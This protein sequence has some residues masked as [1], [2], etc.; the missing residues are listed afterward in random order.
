MKPTTIENLYESVRQR[1]E[2]YPE[3][4]A[5]G[6][7]Q[8]IGWRAVTSRELLALVDQLASEIAVNLGVVSGDRVVLWIPGSWQAPVYH[9]ALWKLGAVIVPLDKDTNRELAVAIMRSVE[10]RV[11]LVGYDYRPEWLTES[12]PV[13]EWWEPG[14]RGGEATE[15][16]VTN[17]LALIAFTSG[18]TGNP[19]GCMISHANLL[20][21]VDALADNVP[22]GPGCRL[23]SVLP[24]S[25]LL[26][27]T[28][29]MLYPLAAG[30]AVHYVPSRRGPDILSVFQQQRITHLIAVPQL[31]GLMGDAIDAQLRKTLPS[32]VYRTLLTVATRVPFAARRRLF[33][34][35][36]QK[37]GGELSMIACG[38]A[39]LPREVQEAWERFGIRVLQGYGASECAP[40]IAC[41]VADGS[42]PVGSVGKPIRGATMRLTLEGEVLVR[43]PN[44]MRGY[45]RDPTRTAEVLQDGWYSTGDLGRI[46]EGGN[47]WILGRA[48]DL[49]VLPSGL[50][51]WPEDLEAVLR[52]HPA[53]KD[54]AVMAVSKP[55]GGLL[56]HTHLIPT[57]DP[58]DAREI[59]AWVNQRLAAHQR[60]ATASWWE[61]A[62]GDFPRTATMKVR[63]HLLPLPTETGPAVPPSLIGDPVGRAVARVLK[64][65]ATRG[66]QTL[67]QLGV[68]SL[69]TLE[70]Q[71]QI[72]DESGKTLPDGFLQGDLTLDDLRRAVEALP[73]D[74]TGDA[75][76]HDLEAAGGNTSR[77]PFTWGRA[78][79]TFAL[80]LDVLFHRAATRIVVSGAENLEDLPRAVI[81]AG[82]HRSYPDLPLLRYAL[83]KTGR[84]ELKD[85]LIIAAAS[86]LYANAG[87][88]G[89][90]GTLLFGIY[91]IQQY[92]R[93][94]ESLS[95]L[96]RL[97]NDGSAILIFP[98]GHHTDP[99]LERAGDPRANF[100]PGV[101]HL[102]D[103]LGASVVPFGAAGSDLIV[104]PHPAADFRGIII[105]GGIPLVIHRAPVAICFGPPL[106]R[107]T[108]E[109][110]A[111]FAT[112]LQQTCFALAR[113]AEAAIGA[114]QESRI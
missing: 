66:D 55:R 75:L 56:L 10:P 74:S 19:K 18:S 27:L 6:G 94:R 36:H 84:A 64:L 93:Q 25:H 79:R 60:L 51:V 3:S 103:A 16:V 22:L 110:P 53:V 106:R 63:R 61:S 21:E 41:A 49:I 89:L 69:T 58:G 78:F 50:N 30:A 44:V 111:A 28:C 65:T 114:E 62:S 1:A 96:A 112:R 39:A 17:E 29:G 108:G 85:R 98:Q 104:P 13:A 88:L 101:A 23:A 14:T 81:F 80:P 15:E 68:D 105:P 83:E 109:S 54:A 57:G 70:L 5:F 2:R 92:R 45:W 31:L 35:V 77:W 59:V 12:D 67:A 72:E 71:T 9:F 86:T 11:V 20:H 46:D 38:G 99:A 95:E 34:A 26:E 73:D 32:P 33:S 76:A 40:V 82:T 91:P 47:L 90:I 8:G 43:G 97:A 4:I 87:L 7:R 37:L 100:R 48:R 52:A 24:L 102:A 107:Q 113:Q 42:T